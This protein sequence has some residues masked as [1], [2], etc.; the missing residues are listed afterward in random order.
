MHWSG[1]RASLTLPHANKEDEGLY[2]LRVVMGDYYEEYS[3]YVFVR[4]RTLSW[5]RD[6][7]QKWG[8]HAGTSCHRRARCFLFPQ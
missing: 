2:T 6:A 4:G 8:R 1:E 3:N 7:L 5:E